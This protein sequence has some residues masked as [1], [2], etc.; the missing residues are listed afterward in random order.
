MAARTPHLLVG[1]TI[2]IT[3]GTSGIGRALVD[4]A[5]GSG[6]RVLTCGRDPLRLASLRS[7]HP[8]V[9]AVKADLGC[10][11]DLDRFIET[12]RTWTDELDILV[13]NAADPTQGSFTRSPTGT[14]RRTSTDEI[15]R[16]IATNLT[17]PIVLTAALLPAIGVSTVR[18]VMNV[19]SALALA[20]VGRAPLYGASKAGLRSFTH[21]L[22]RQL[23]GTGIRVLEALPPLTDTPMAAAVQKPKVLP[24][25]WAATMFAAIASGNHC[26]T[27]PNQRRMQLMD[28]ATVL[29]A[30]GLR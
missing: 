6:M 4:A 16:A 23:A 20:P 30:R 11:D 27:G 9:C 24:A 3:G 25:T 10:D 22:D 18:T 7:D 13:N 17:A 12:S 8:D 28:A 2:I 14:A 15:R 29:A 21:A 5:V 26:S 1:R 19:T